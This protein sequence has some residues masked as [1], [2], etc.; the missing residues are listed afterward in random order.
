MIGVQIF[1]TRTPSKRENIMDYGPRRFGRFTLAALFIILLASIRDASAARRAG[2]AVDDVLASDHGSRSNRAGV[3]MAAREAALH[4][5]VQRG[6]VKLIAVPRKHAFKDFVNVTIDIF[7]K[8][9]EKLQSPPCYELCAFN[10][11]YDE[12]VQNV[13]KGVFDGAVRD[14]TITDDRARI[15]DFTMPYAPSGQMIRSPLSKVVVVIWCFA[16]LVLVQSYTA[17]LSSMLTAK[18]LRPSVTGLDQLVSNGDYIRYQDGAFVHFFLISKGPKADRLRAFKNQTEYAE[19]LRKGSKN[20]GVSAI[21]DEIP[22]LSYFLSD[23][24]NKEFEMGERLYKTPGL[25]FVFPR[26]SPRMYDLSVAILNLTG[27]NESARIEQEW[28]GSPAQL[29]GDSSSIADSAPLTLRSFSGLFVITG[30]ISASV[31]VISIARSVYAKC[32]R[33]RGHVSQDGNGGSVRH[34]EFSA[35]QND[36]GNGFVPDERL[37]EIRGNNSQQCAPGSGRSTGDEEAGPM[38]D[39]MPNGSVPEVSIQIEMSDT[40]QGVGRGL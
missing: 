37:H 2:G 14:M 23:K 29:K 16:V 12:L 18:R 26:G 25:G 32:F 13:S 21:V 22:Y 34:G 19:A 10:G 9:I 1:P 39:S 4:A 7:R 30:S 28:L 15:A 31:T 33:A 5:C 40:G 36:R 38:Q 20:D 8:A 35:L 11:T 27:G 17:N 24:N 6:Y 3:S